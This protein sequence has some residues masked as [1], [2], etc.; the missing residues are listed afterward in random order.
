[1]NSVKKLDTTAGFVGNL[2]FTK[3][4]HFLPMVHMVTHTKTLVSGEKYHGE[5]CV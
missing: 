4:I 1:M 5:F 2:L 3:K